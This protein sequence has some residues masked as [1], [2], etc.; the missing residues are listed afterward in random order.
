[1]SQITNN[2]NLE[3]FIFPNHEK[4]CFPEIYIK[5]V[6]PVV[7]GELQLLRGFLAKCLRCSQKDVKLIPTSSYRSRTHNKKVGGVE[8]SSHKYDVYNNDE[9]NYFLW[10]VDFE[11]HTN[12]G[13]VEKE[14]LKNLVQQLQHF[15]PHR[16]ILVTGNETAIHYDNRPQCK[17]M[18]LL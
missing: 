5:K 18:G 14:D 2:F 9:F 16:N 4:Y 13:R 10:A 7:A 3:E 6:M 11:F 15:I 17:I 12:L 1:M 8:N